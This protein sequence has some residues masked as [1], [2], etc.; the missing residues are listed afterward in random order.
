MIGAIFGHWLLGIPISLLSLFG[1]IALAGVVVNDSLILVDFVNRHRRAGEPRIEAAIKA[2]RA[3]F[4]AIILTSMTTFLGL[5]PII[6]FETSLQA[7]IVIPMATSLA[8]GIVFATVITLGLIPILYLIADDV[9]N[10]AMRL[11]GREP[12]SAATIKS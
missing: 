8:F 9:T 7:Q 5:A 1:I 2:A 11:L 6:F 12:D 3:R 4:R 10:Q